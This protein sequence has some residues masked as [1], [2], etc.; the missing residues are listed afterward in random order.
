MLAQLPA[1][2]NLQPAEVITGNVAIAGPDTRER[3][4]VKELD[5]GGRLSMSDKVLVDRSG[6]TDKV[7]RVL[8][9]VGSRPARRDPIDTRIVQSVIR[10]DGAII[11][12]QDQVGGYPVR[13]RTTRALKVPDE[14]KERQ[15]WLESLS[16]E[17]EAHLQTRKDERPDAFRIVRASFLVHVVVRSL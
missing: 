8:R 11:D 5:A 17:I 9:S 10:G 12:S 1:Q 14:I 15:R 13:A 6:M 16:R 4:F 2:E 7:S 3:R